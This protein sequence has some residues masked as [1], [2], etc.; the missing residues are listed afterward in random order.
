MRIFPPVDWRF[1]GEGTWGMDYAPD[2]SHVE[3]L[4]THGRR[5]QSGP[6]QYE[7]N[8]HNRPFGLNKFR[9]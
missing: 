3:L 5:K 7:P 9:R 1:S 8:R 6:G 4:W 2:W